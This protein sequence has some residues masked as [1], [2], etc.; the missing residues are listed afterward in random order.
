[1][2]KLVERQVIVSWYRPEEKLPPEEWDTILLTVSG[3][4][5]RV[6]YD[7]AL[8]LGGYDPKVGWYLNGWEDELLDNFTVHAWADIDPYKG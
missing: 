2:G 7:H 6:K 1:M 4:G 5:K 3:T 8:T